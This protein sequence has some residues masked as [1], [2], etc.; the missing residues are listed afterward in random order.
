MKVHSLVPKT[1][2]RIFHRPKMSSFFPLRLLTVS[3][4]SPLRRSLATLKAPLAQ[5]E[6]AEQSS[7]IYQ[8]S[9][10]SFDQMVSTEKAESKH[11]II[12]EDVSRKLVNTDPTIVSKVLDWP[13]SKVYR[14]KVARDHFFLLKLSDYSE[15][16]KKNKPSHLSES[17]PVKS[18]MVQV[19]N[20][21]HVPEANEVARSGSD[22]DSVG[23]QELSVEGKT[24]ESELEHLSRSMSLTEYGSKIRFFLVNQLEEMLCGGLFSNFTINP[25]GSSV[26]GF[27]SDSSDL[28]MAFQSAT[29][30]NPSTKLTYC[31]KELLSSREVSKRLVM[32]FSDIISWYVPGFIGVTAITRA[33][34]PIVRMYSRFTGLD[35]DIAFQS[36]NSI[37]MAR[38]LFSLNKIEPKLRHLVVFGRM[39]L[40]RINKDSKNIPGYFVSN[41]MLTAMIINFLQTYEHGPLL[42]AI[43]NLN[44]RPMSRTPGSELSTREL[45][46][47]FFEFLATF[48]FQGHGMSILNSKYIVKSTHS[49]IYVENPCDIEHNICR[50]VTLDDLGRLRKA[51]Q[52]TVQVMTSREQASIDSV[53]E[54]VDAV[55]ASSKGARSNVIKPTTH[56]QSVSIKDF[57]K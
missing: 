50:N 6:N 34:V 47:K 48:D 18:R 54:A 37:E 53:L 28:D 26:N 21:S 19:R 8:D 17:L 29:D 44:K 55:C 1:C 43:K 49:P 42:P 4:H 41:F 5:S 11:F 40:D 45:L 10:S 2:G 31:T 23:V 33:R 32:T 12:L 22:V 20:V 3:C 35:C 52:R 7:V 16:C 14:V 51:A 36:S 27:G 24:M 9:F 46:E 30:Q 15:F 39:W 56:A 25:F 38:I 13:V 57:W